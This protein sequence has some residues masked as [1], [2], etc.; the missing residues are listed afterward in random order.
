MGVLVVELQWVARSDFFDFSVGA[1][2]FCAPP[3][4]GILYGSKKVTSYLR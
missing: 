2:E 4:D 1:P 3:A